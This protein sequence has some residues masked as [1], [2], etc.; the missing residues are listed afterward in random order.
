LKVV[1]SDT[2]PINYLVLIGKQDILPSLFERIMIPH[3]VYR[4]LNAEASPPEIREWIAVAPDWL[5]IRPPTKPP[6]RILSQLGEG[7]SAAIQLAEELKADLLV[8][9]E[10]AGR[11][12]ALKRGLPVI[13]TLGILERASERGLLDF[14][15]T[16]TEMKARNFFRLAGAGKGLPRT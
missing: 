12:E 4:E 14:A 11:E 8:M 7:E 13:G 1:I 2:S 16:F 5:E 9:D 6:V 3:A 15:I 10:R